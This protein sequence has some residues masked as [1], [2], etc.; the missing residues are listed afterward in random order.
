MIV[1][2]IIMIN[3]V[4]WHFNQI[5]FRFLIKMKGWFIGGNFSDVGVCFH[6][7]VGCNFRGV[8]SV[9]HNSGNAG[10][11]GICLAKCGRPSDWSASRD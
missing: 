9:G 7:S 11:N 4:G 6:C 3:E 2:Y 8:R 5:Y 10:D 1:S